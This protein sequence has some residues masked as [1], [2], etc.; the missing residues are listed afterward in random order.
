MPPEGGA[1]TIVSNL[2]LPISDS[3]YLLNQH[4]VWKV[5]VSKQ[6]ELSATS[7]K[8]VTRKDLAVKRPTTGYKT[9]LSQTAATVAQ[10]SSVL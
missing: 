5:K 6:G 3:M 1:L 2:L 9:D 10:V 7:P 8:L 4:I